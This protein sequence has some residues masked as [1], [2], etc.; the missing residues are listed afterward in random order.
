MPPFSMPVAAPSY[1]PP[2]YEFRRARQTWV[3]YEAD[4]SLFIDLLPSG[5][6]PD[7]DP[8]V[9]AAWACHYPESSF[10]PYLEAY[11]VVRVQVGE[12][13]FWYQPVIV[14]D[15]ETP[16][17]AGREVWGYGKKLAHLTWS[18]P[19]HG[20]PGTEQLAMTVERP[21]RLR[22][23]TLT[24][25]PERLV[26]PDELRALP[27][28]EMLPTLSH[29]LVPSVEAGQPPTADD[30][31]AVDVRPRAHRGAD[32]RPEIWRGAGA[33]ELHST[34]ADPWGAFRALRVLDAF[35]VT[36]DFALPH[37]RVVPRDTTPS[38]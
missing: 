27:T 18:D 37:G 28:A 1:P 33:V 34:A 22:L 12:E 20:G 19:G 25:R 24:M 23:M 30:L 3:V 15:S 16:L 26:E 14:T 2:P 29:R 11:L 13:R 8:A 31:I 10:G 32:G 36:S 7:S 9:C 21:R 38:I 5:V 17:A 6:R 4:P 35:S